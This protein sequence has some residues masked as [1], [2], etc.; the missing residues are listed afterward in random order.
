MY[1]CVFETQMSGASILVAAMKPFCFRWSSC[2]GNR[3]LSLSMRLER[4]E[5]IMPLSLERAREGGGVRKRGK[6]VMVMI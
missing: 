3:L 4:C 1:L 6:V 5:V 2:L